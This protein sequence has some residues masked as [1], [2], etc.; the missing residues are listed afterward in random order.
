M[1]GTLVAFVADIREFFYVAGC[2]IVCRR[3]YV[4]DSMSQILCRR[5]YVADSMSQIL[6][7]CVAE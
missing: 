1:S 7:R 3:F 6:C 2:D 5:F 4:A